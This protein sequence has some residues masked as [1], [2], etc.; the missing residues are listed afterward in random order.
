MRLFFL[1]LLLVHWWSGMPIRVVHGTVKGHGVASLGERTKRTT[2]MLTQR[3]FV[4][5][6][7]ASR[8]LHVH[9]HSL[10]FKGT[11]MQELVQLPL[12]EAWM[13]SDK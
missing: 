3:A 13:D 5:H 2:S 9:L 4:H 8:A 1:S 11:R 12:G 10:I 6:A 7:P